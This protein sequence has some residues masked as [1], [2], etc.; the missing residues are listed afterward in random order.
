MHTDLFELEGAS[1]GVVMGHGHIGNDLDDLARSHLSA[2]LLG[3]YLLYKGLFLGGS[4]H[5]RNAF[6]DVLINPTGFYPTIWKISTTFFLGPA[7][8]TEVFG[9]HLKAAFSLRNFLTSGSLSSRLG[10]IERRKPS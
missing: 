10:V 4:P 8:L 9:N 3:E 6:P 7:G 5:F 2:Q 1:G